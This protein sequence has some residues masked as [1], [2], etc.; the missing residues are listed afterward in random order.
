MCPPNT[1]GQRISPERADKFLERLVNLSP[2]GARPTEDERTFAPFRAFGDLL[3]N[4]LPEEL[5]WQRLQRWRD[6]LRVCWHGKVRDRRMVAARLIKIY[7]GELFVAELEKDLGFDLEKTPPIE[8]LIKSVTAS[9]RGQL[10]EPGMIAS[11]MDYGPFLQVLFRAWEIAPKMGLCRNRTCEHPFFIVGA[12][13]R[14]TAPIVVRPRRSGQPN[15][16]GGIQLER[17]AGRNPRRPGAGR[18]H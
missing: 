18:S 4:D 5:S 11:Q 1:I 14:S 7:Q 6:D 12:R 10:R 15:C 13:L 2:P 8:A 16:D 9:V 17:N 3:P